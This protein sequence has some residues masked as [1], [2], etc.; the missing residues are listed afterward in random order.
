MISGH[1]KSIGI[2]SEYSDNIVKVVLIKR[3]KDRIIVNH[4]IHTLYERGQG[5]SSSVI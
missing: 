1:V 2:W 5:T 4:R 3:T